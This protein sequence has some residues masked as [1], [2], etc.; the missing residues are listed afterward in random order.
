MWNVEIWRIKRVGTFE[1]LCGSFKIEMLDFK[2]ELLFWKF[3]VNP[4]YIC[5]NY[6]PVIG[7]PP[8]TVY[9]SLYFGGR[10][11]YILFHAIIA[12]CHN[13]FLGTSLMVYVHYNI[14]V[15]QLDNLLLYGKYI[16]D[17]AT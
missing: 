11:T 5:N 2:N 10:L 16:T 3:V 17:L 8:M 15:V 4:N 12:I 1:I 7:L 14:G 13:V 9:T 6:D